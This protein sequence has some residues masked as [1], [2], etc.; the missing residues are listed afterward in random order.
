MSAPAIA[1]LRTVLLL[2][3]TGFIGR[4]LLDALQ[5]AGY[6]VI[7]GVRA[8]TSLP[9]CRSIEVDYSRDHRP[10]DW[11]PRLAGVDAV[12][13]AVGILR[14]TSGASFEALHVATPGA[15]FR[16]CAEAGVRKII[17]ISALG[18]DNHAVSRYHL[19]KKEADDI[20]ARLRVPWIIVQPSLVFGEG[21]ASATLFTTL[22][23]LPLVPVPGDGRQHIQPIH[24]DDLTDALMRVLET[25]GCDYRRLAAVGARPVTLRELL[26]VLR[27]AMGLGETHFVQVPL[28]LVRAAATLGDRLPGMLLDRES[29]GMLIR[30]NIATPAPITAVLGRRPRPVESF[31][32]PAAARALADAARLA[33][34]L[35]LLR[36]TVAMVWIVTGIVSLG[37]YPVNESY[38]LLARVGLAGAAA[39]V[40]LYGAALLDLVLG[41]ATLTMRRRRRLWQAQ[42]LLIVGY[43][44]IITVFLPEFWLHPYGPVL[45][46]LPL[47]AAILMLHEFDR[48]CEQ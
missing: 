48:P 11:L 29:L 30:G 35:P 18:A 1:P 12:I 4:R 20:L 27:R 15:I 23:A 34:L 22:A 19:S 17:Q 14:E 16:A 45:K 38:A 5:H 13:N 43:T 7:C 21:G 3:A 10:G 6:D 39:T 28:P 44:L 24:V 25:S 46:N 33:W 9:Q 8:G 36:V 37:V 32:P 47:L 42:M 2:G 41:V 31:I 26:A 40:A